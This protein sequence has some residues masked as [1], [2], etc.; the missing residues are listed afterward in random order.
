MSRTDDRTKTRSQ[1]RLPVIKQGENDMTI[2]GDPRKLPQFNGR[3]MANVFASGADA[4]LG[5]QALGYSG[6]V[7]CNG[8]QL[9][10]T[11]KSWRA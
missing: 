8:T 2:S 5:R 3:A 1:R 9:G 6:G 7:S 11:L 4:I 10:V